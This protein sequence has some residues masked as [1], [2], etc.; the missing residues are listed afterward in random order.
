MPKP[1]AE[2][3]VQTLTFA[4]NNFGSDYHVDGHSSLPFFSGKV[5]RK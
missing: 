3:T 4:V 2:V 1:K 5:Q